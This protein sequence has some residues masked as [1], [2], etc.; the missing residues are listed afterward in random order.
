MEHPKKH[1]AKAH[2]HFFRMMMSD[3][4]VT[5]EFFE[6][7]LPKDVL[8]V[9]NLDK[10]ELQSSGYIDIYAKNPLRICCLKQR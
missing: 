5:R 8:A 9:T 4:R 3:I 2:D 10:L 6:I 1:I 7:H